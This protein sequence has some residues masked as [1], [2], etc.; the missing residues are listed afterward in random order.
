MGFGVVVFRHGS[1]MITV[2]CG[3]SSGDSLEGCESA[4]F[5][6]TKAHRSL[7][8]LTGLE[9]AIAQGNDAA[10][11]QAKVCVKQ[12]QASSVLYRK[13]VQS[14]LGQL[15]TRS[16]LDAYHVHLALAAVGQGDGDFCTPCEVADINLVGPAWKAPEMDPPSAGLSCTIRWAGL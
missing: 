6:W 2:T 10:D 9:L 16:M 8:G 5:V 3:N 1:R 15:K 11:Q 13:V 14:K 7:S 12:Y 4:E